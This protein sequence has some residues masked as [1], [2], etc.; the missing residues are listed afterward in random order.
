[1]SCNG[2]KYVCRTHGFGP[3]SAWKLFSAQNTGQ[4]LLTTFCH[5][6]EGSQD[7]EAS[8][9]QGEPQCTAVP[10]GVTPNKKMQASGILLKIHGKLRSGLTHTEGSGKGIT[11][12]INTFVKALLYFKAEI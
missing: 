12:A 3:H 5:R 7:T 9:G 1:M 10:T 2:I 6:D 4:H 11:G 8:N